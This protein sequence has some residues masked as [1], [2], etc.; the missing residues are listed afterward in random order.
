MDDG[1]TFNHAKEGEYT[2]AEFKYTEGALH[3]DLH[4]SNYRLGQSFLIDSINIYG[5]E[6]K[7]SSLQ[8]R[9]GSL[10]SEVEFKH[11]AGL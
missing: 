8:M 5:L 6:T 7:P 2:L 11:V 10:G 4:Q 9:D 1:T 3:I